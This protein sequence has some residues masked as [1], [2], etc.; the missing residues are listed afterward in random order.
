MRH[1]DITG[2]CGE[3]QK[4]RKG[5]F[6]CHRSHEMY[7]MLLSQNQI[8]HMTND[9]ACKIIYYINIINYIINVCKYTN[10][11]MPYMR[12]QNLYIGRL[13]A[14]TPFKSSFFF[15]FFSEIGEERQEA[16]GTWELSCH[17]G[18]HLHSKKY[19]FSWLQLDTTRKVMMEF[20][21]MFWNPRP[22]GIWRV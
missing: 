8:S 4:R 14:S 12:H 19:Q 7:D 18:D 1:S 3:K 17:C 11:Y 16:V 6:Q 5:H 15:F 21:P 20:Q 22:E 2:S 13:V 9:I 10:V